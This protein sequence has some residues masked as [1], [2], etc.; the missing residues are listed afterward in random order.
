MERITF[1]IV[2]DTSPYGPAQVMLVTPDQYERLVQGGVHPHL[3]AV[4]RL[5]ELAEAVRFGA[6]PTETLVAPIDNGRIL[7]LIGLGERPT[8]RT[9]RDA[10]AQAVSTVPPQLEWTLLVDLAGAAHAAPDPASAALAVVE[11]VATGAYRF[12]HST[13]APTPVPGTCHLVVDGVNDDLVSR[14]LARTEG[15][16]LTRDLVNTPAEQLGPAELAEAAR[17]VAERHGM[18]VRTLTGDQVM[19]EGFKLTAVT[20]RAADRPP[21][22]TIVEAGPEGREPDLALV[23][24]GVVYD[25]GGLNLKTGNYMTLMRKDMGGAGT[26]IG[27]LDALGRLGFD[28]ALMAVIPAAENAIGPGAMRP[29]DVFEAF[30]GQK[31][32]IGNTD[33]EGRLLL[34]DGLCYARQ[35]GAKRILDVATLTGA[36]RVALG[37][38]VPALFGT[39]EELVAALLETSNACDEPVWRMPLVDGYDW[40]IDS[41]FADVSNSGSDARGGAITAALFLRRF[42][43]ET[44]WAHVDLY[45]WEDRGRP[46]TPRGANGM[47]VRTLATAVQRLLGR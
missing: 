42:V 15:Q 44:P 14:A 26:V 41:P 34:A 32:E 30:D 4:P 31:V 39:D 10:A 12:T 38:D 5:A 16:L 36:A 24:K 19:G 8:G 28:G 13:K 17:E 47:F 1:D 45:A 7:H 3:G 2:P 40:T 6:K 35:R 33:A 11:G 20:G 46:G 37:P 27:A 29:G 9:L 18:R 21:T 22:V 23:G 43:K 25:T